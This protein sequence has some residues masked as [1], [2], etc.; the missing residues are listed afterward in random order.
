MTTGS[1]IS[2]CFGMAIRAQTTNIGE[3]YIN[4]G[5]Q[6]STIMPFNNTPSGVFIND[7]DAYIYANW[8]NDGV[9]DFSGATGLTR[10]VGDTVQ[11]ITG[12]QASYLYNCLFN[13]IAA[14]HA[15]ELSGTISITNEVEYNN[16]IVDN[17]S[18]GG[19]FIFEQEA[20][21]VNTN[22]DSHINGPV[23]KN[24]STSFT[25][26]VGAGGFYR[27]A[28]ISAPNTGSEVFTSKYFFE[29]TNVNY[30]I[31][32]RSSR[33][34]H[35]DNAEHWLIERTNGN[36][37]VLITLSWNKAITPESIITEPYNAI[38]IA[39]W[40]DDLKSWV[41]EGGLVNKDAQTVTTAVNKYGVFTLARINDDNMLPCGLLVH[42]L[43]TPNKDGINDYLKIKTA[44]GR[45]SCVKRLGIKVFNRWGIKV[46]ESDDY[47]V[48]GNVFSGF[49]NGRLTISKNNKLPTG[50]YYYILEVDYTNGDTSMVQTVKKAD[51][52]YIN[53]GHN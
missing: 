39:R 4:P 42:N 19:D 35:I 21:H 28:G 11:Q 50:T 37:D 47:G 26:P 51:Y 14:Q 29:D 22:D 34:E 18:Y 9:V 36:T 38:H 17:E 6:F 7:G 30:P 24:G 52:L 49:S 46:F 15:F 25:Y 44:T 31:A 13:N 3:L 32:K 41:D 16:G 40:D 1:L 8:N 33:L 48:D 5:T 45:A 23:I 43:I 53:G 2:V 27:L 12:S 10:Y 20:I